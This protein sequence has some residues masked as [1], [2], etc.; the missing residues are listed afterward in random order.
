MF[1]N[2]VAHPQRNSSINIAVARVLLGGYVAWKIFSYDWT[3]LQ[4]WPRFL[5]QV[6]YNRFLLPVPGYVSYVPLEVCAVGVLLLGFIF[7]YRIAVCGF[8]GAL[9][10]AHVAGIQFML[11][12]HRMLL[13]AVHL[14]LF[15][16]VFRNTDLL[17]LDAVRRT[18]RQPLNELNRFL[19]SSG[20]ALYRMDVLKWALLMIAVHY[21]VI[22]MSKMIIGPGPAW[23]TAENLSRIIHYEALLYLTG[24]PP[25]GQFLLE[26]PWLTGI[27]AWAT[28]IL[29]CGLVIAVLAKQPITPF[30]L[31][32]AGMHTMIALSM[33]LFFLDLYI[34]MAMFLPWDRLFARVMPN[35]PL[36]L[37]YDDKCAFCVRTLTFVK[38]LDVHRCIR[39][40]SQS[41]VPEAHT[42]RVD[43]GLSKSLYAFAEGN[44]Y[45]GYDAFREL[46]RRYPIFF[47]LAWLKR[48]CA[49]MAGMGP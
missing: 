38:R 16:A 47:P 29:E 13:I 48:R 26:Q 2:Y 7:G 11:T 18:Q 9:L 35:R 43:T 34:F 24:I 5:F 19:K 23:A 17:S 12:N 36:D 10:L 40:Y 45:S 41:D 33:H 42:R 14:L 8:L 22:G 4:E 1:V 37:L 44:V 28:L 32:L 39:F 30:L 49:H 46:L 21:A 27:S 3:T 15:F 20:A 31:G 25:V 6:H